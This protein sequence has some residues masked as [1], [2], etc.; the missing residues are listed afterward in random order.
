MN[1]TSPW[2]ERVPTKKEAPTPLTPLSLTEGFGC[3]QRS[4]KCLVR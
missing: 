2:T 4:P 1:F 3:P